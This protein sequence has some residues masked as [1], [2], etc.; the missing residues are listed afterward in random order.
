MKVENLD[1]VL[2]PC[3]SISLPPYEPI[4]ED[5]L[6]RFFLFDAIEAWL[7]INMVTVS[8]HILMIIMALS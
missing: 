7:V 3:K 4:N 1:L 8:T 2:N 5:I 6:Q